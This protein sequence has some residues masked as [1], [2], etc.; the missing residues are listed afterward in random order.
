[1]H[2]AEHHLLIRQSWAAATVDQ[3]ALAHRFYRKLFERAPETEALFTSD[4]EAQGRKLVATLAFVV[5]TL[6]DA[7]TLLSA[8]A[9]L[10][11]RH[12]AYDVRAEHYADVGGALIETLQDML[13]RRFDAPTQA[14]WETTYDGL[15]QHMIQVAY[16]SAAEDT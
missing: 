6:D 10:A 3:A 7:Q 1:M 5:D 11:L 15:A 12:V 9:E 16:G 13:G 4:M 8:S 2:S 14:A